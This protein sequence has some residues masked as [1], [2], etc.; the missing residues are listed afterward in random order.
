MLRGTHIKYQKLYSREYVVLEQ[1]KV[2]DQLT[3]HSSQ[4]WSAF[5]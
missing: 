1:L 2:G 3:A 4:R 5:K